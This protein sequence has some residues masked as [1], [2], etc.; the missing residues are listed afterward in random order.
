MRPGR[1]TWGEAVGDGVFA[2]YEPIISGLISTVLNTLPLYTPTTLPIIS[3]TITCCASASPRLNFSP[4]SPPS[5]RAASSSACTC[6][7]AALELADARAEHQHEL[8]VGHVGAGR[9]PSRGRTC[10]TCASWARQPYASS[11]ALCFFVSFGG[12]AGRAVG[13]APG[14][15]EG[16][17]VPGRRA[18]AGRAR[19]AARAPRRSGDGRRPGRRV[20]GGPG[21]ARG[22]ADRSRPKEC[23]SARAAGRRA[24]RVD[25]GDAHPGR[26]TH[27]ARILEADHGASGPVASVLEATPA[28]V[29][30]ISA[31][32]RRFRP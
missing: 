12:D 14:D 15:G 3:G 19:G 23:G 8:V 11:A 4:P 1:V 28:P 7:Q 21:R 25:V 29:G 30:V 31:R 17:A 20:R 26:D 22:L 18:R 16:G 32:G 13:G 6:L 24:G 2:E 9:G 27:R 10:G 5:P